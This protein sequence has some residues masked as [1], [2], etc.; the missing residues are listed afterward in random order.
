MAGFVQASAARRLE[1]Q[2]HRRSG[3]L[4]PSLELPM[5]PWGPELAD[6]LVDVA[7]DVVV[8]QATLAGSRAWQ[9]DDDGARLR[10]DAL[11]TIQSIRER[12]LALDLTITEHAVHEVESLVRAWEALTLRP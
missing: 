4:M 9:H 11:T 6:D 2:I 1:R 10:R 8:L 7:S 5:P 12:C 3:A